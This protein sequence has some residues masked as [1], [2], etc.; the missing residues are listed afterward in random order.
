MSDKFATKK[1]NLILALVLIIVLAAVVASVVVLR[2]PE[3]S[4]SASPSQPVTDAAGQTQTDAQASSDENTEVLSELPTPEGIDLGDGLIITD[5][6]P[7][8]GAYLE[9]G[10]GE[11]VTDVLTIVVYNDGDAPIQ[12]AEITLGDANFTL[13]TLPVGERMMIQE[14]DRK[15]YDEKADY[16]QASSRHVAKFDES[17]SL[18]Q[19]KIRIQSLEDAM[20]IINISG[21]DI[22][23]DVIIYYKNS[24]TDLLY[25]GITYR[26]RLTGGM[27]ANEVR[28]IMSDH[29][30]DSGSRVMF[31][32]CG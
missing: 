13:T 30:S 19:D 2:M 4:Q 28:Q 26:V 15:T 10:S 11:Q 16:S 8:T 32:T 20:N 5:V 25:G 7:Y 21:E 18:C 9:D 12:Y 31:I 24:S 22:E 17:L 27:K 23:G 3:D 6:G 1:N 29:Y 14:K